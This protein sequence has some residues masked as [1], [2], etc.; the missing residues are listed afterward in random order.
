MGDE[1]VCALL[2]PDGL[3]SCFGSGMVC[4]F[5]AAWCAFLAALEGDGSSAIMWRYALDEAQ[6]LGGAQSET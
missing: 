3:V 6:F 5:R 2:A 4:V 1:D